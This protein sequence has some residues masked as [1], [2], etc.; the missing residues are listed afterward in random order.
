M[1]NTP[2]YQ[3]TT[4]AINNNYLMK[5]NISKRDNISQ[6]IVCLLLCEVFYLGLNIRH[7][8]IHLGINLG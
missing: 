2:K 3:S 6:I 4:D 1:S 7:H 5:N 8:P